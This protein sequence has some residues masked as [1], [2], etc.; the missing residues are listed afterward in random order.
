M[1]VILDALKKAQQD[2]KKLELPRKRSS[3]GSGPGN[4]SRWALYSLLVIVVAGVLF[5]LFYSG[6]KTGKPTQVV[7]AAKV[8]PN[9]VPAQKQEPKANVETAP[10][11]EEK[12]VAQVKQ[13]KVSLPPAK[14]AV[15]S[16]TKVAGAE[17][18]RPVAAKKKTTAV[19]AA[20]P[21]RA[22]AVKE[23]PSVPK[24]EKPAE[25][26]RIIMKRSDEERITAMYNEAARK[27]DSGRPHEARKIYEDILRERPGHAEVLNNLGV[28]AM[29]EGK[30]DEARSRF[31]KALE[32]RKD[33]A[34]AYNNMG[35]LMMQEGKG[36]LAEEYFRKS[37]DIDGNS[38]E[39]YLNLTALLRSEK[40]QKDA[41]TLLERVINRDVADN[42]LYLSFAIIK[43]EMAQYGDAIKYYRL[44]LRT[45]GDTAQRDRVIKRLKVLEDNQVT[46][47]R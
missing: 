28:M 42:A 26:S 15:D 18:T 44:F 3:K 46:A 9:T 29:N 37:I 10:A 45:G 1:S 23:T 17:K 12:P 34:K 8:E 7:A 39:P 33:Y 32:Y 24:A 11:K 41:S 16:K 14:P 25:E 31:S 19:A 27:A 20:S 2:K 6:Q 36:K 30:V 21:V 13:P 38:I 5:A 22:A 35:L 43:D 4:K 47:N 40:R